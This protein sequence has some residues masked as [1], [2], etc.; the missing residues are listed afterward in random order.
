[1]RRLEI[2]VDQPTRVRLPEPF[3]HEAR[4]DEQRLTAAQRPRAAGADVDVSSAFIEQV[5]RRTDAAD[6]RADGLRPLADEAGP[7]ESS[8]PA[9]G[10][11]GRPLGPRD[12]LGTPALAKVSSL[13]TRTRAGTH[14]VNVAESVDLGLDA[15]D[16]R[17]KMRAAGA[18]VVGEDAVALAAVQVPVRRAVR[19]D[20]VELG[21]V[22]DGFRVGLGTGRPD[23]PARVS[24]EGRVGLDQLWRVEAV[25]LRRVVERPATNCSNFASAISGLVEETYIQAATARHRRAAWRRCAAQTRVCPHRDR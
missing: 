11:A 8:G 15:L 17:Q 5:P 4:V 13:E 22:R 3:V 25:L 14:L 23:G 19:H 9:P 7:F 16:G 20:E 12:Y 6:Q 1:M 2:D 21:A 18:H 10:L 24:V